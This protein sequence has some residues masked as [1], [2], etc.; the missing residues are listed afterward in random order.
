MDT[1]DT[2]KATLCW[3]D[4]EVGYTF[5]GELRSDLDL[6]IVDKNLNTVVYAYSLDGD[7]P[8]DVAR[9]D[10]FNRIDNVEQ[11]AVKLPKGDYT[12]QVSVHKAGKEQQAYTLVS[13]KVL[14]NWQENSSY[15]EIEEFE[16]V[17]YESV[18]E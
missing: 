6:T 8:E 15:S 11:I 7:N 4:P 16:T 9:Q 3:I 1:L 10:R 17:I 13:N 18:L 12:V 5:D 14:K 2:F